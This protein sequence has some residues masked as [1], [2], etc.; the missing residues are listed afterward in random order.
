[1]VRYLIRGVTQSLGIINGVS[2]ILYMNDQVKDVI[3][4]LLILLLLFRK[5]SQRELT[6]GH[7]D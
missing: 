1:M 6:L 7:L 5:V 2:K 3:D 4:I